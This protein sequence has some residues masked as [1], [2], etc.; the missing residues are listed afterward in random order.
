[1]NPDK[2]NKIKSNSLYKVP[3]VFRD[4][5]D[6]DLP[7]DRKKSD[8]VYVLSFNQQTDI[9]RNLS[10]YGYKVVELNRLKQRFMPRDLVAELIDAKAVLVNL[11]GVQKE[12]NTNKLND[13]QLMCLAGICVS[14]C[15]PVKI[16]QSNDNFY[17]DVR[18]IS[19]GGNSGKNLIEFVNGLSI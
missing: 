19:I 11:S 12:Q 1:M 14:Q 7:N 8:A 10:E 6:F 9:I 18:E 4:I 17:S 13:S 2:F 3:R 15:V 16:F 5:D